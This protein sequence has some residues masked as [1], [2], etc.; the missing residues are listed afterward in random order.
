MNQMSNIYGRY[1]M[2]TDGDYVDGNGYIIY[3]NSD[4]SSALYYKVIEN[5]GEVR[6]TLNFRIHLIPI[7][8][9]S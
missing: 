8:R 1:L 9:F 5:I 7:G 4:A 2:N 3:T 6:L